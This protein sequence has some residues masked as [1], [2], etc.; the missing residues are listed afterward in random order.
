MYDHK[1]TDGEMMNLVVHEM[2][3]LSR[4]RNWI[5]GQFTQKVNVDRTAVTQ[6]SK[7]Q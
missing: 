6:V 2:F 4:C 7:R 1:N 3:R 5:A